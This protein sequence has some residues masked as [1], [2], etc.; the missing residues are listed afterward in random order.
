[1]RYLEKGQHFGE[2]KTQLISNGII[3]NK[4]QV[5]SFLDIPWH[6][7][8]NAYFLYNL[9]GDYHEVTKKA[10]TDI[11]PGSLLFHHSQDPHYNK[12]IKTTVD[13]FHVE[14]TSTWFEKYN[15]KSDF[16]EGTLQL[17]NPL[18][19]SIFKQLHTEMDINDSASGIAIDS[20]ILQAF[21]KIIRSNE[22]EILKK[23]LWVNKIQEIINDEN[24]DKLTLNT[25]AN[26]VNLHPV[27]LS[28]KFPIYFNE[29]LGDYIRN[30]KLEKAADLLQNS[31]FGNSEIA[32]DCGFA[33]ESHFI[34][35]FKT[36]FDLTP[37]Q[38]RKIFKKG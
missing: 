19:K 3:L 11:V 31:V 32:Y 18:L 23:P 8:E 17:K 13:F 35:L 4:A 1:M 14:I 28:R 20:L 36:Y 26:E 6:Y 10:V 7:H 22:K 21:S 38:Y 24:W 33:D 12:N 27:Y 5:T 34:K 37:N 29:N 9:K 2:N 25:I 16:I 15:L 30:K